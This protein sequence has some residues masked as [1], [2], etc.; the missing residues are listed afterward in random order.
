[1]IMNKTAAFI[2]LRGGSKS[3]PG[4]NI[5]LM[6][7]KPL[8][9]WVISTAAECSNIDKVFVATESPEIRE[10][11]S[12]FGFE[13]VLVVSRSEETA[14]DTASTESALIEFALEQDQYGTLILIQATSPLLTSEDLSSAVE[15]Y[16]NGTADSMLSVV[17]QKRFLWHVDNE[18]LATA[19]NYDPAARPRRQDFDGEL[20]ENGAFYVMSREGLLE[21]NC[22]LYGKTS[23]YE[24]PE[25]SYLEIDEPNDWKLTE[26]LLI[27]RKLKQVSKFQRK[28][29]RMFVTDVDGVLTDAGMY[30]SETGDE[31]KKFNTRDGLGLRLLQEAGIV[32]G[33]I[34][35]EKTAIVSRRA[36]KLGVDFVYQ[37]ATDK[38]TLL[39]RECQ[40]RGIELTE[41]AYIGDDV[42]DLACIQSVGQ[43]FCPSDAVTEI[44]KAAGFGLT[45]A[46]GAGAVREACEQILQACK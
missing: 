9:W 25:E 44:R 46:G 8:A 41:V 6:A 4:K 30:Y 32:V 13:K 22:R 28:P 35:S 10:V 38:L 37:N 40:T 16:H 12:A 11:V 5:K 18:G 24:M 20:V 29:V 45:N 23:V 2:P 3:I 14:T 39:K 17:R 33:I 42:N 27:E 36:E 19:V 15:Q 43:S 34:T 1:M 31:L 26:E 21:A 7:G